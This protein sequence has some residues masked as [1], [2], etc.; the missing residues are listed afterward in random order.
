MSSR[1]LR[2]NPYILYPDCSRNGV[3]RA[4][5]DMCSRA[6]FS[7]ALSKSTLSTLRVDLLL[8]LL[9][10]DR[11]S[12]ILNQVRDFC[13]DESCTVVQSKAIYATGVQVVGF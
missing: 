1:R 12:K 3:Y 11:A 6:D 4:L 13:G 10:D 2:G 9:A 7:R 8:G 5:V